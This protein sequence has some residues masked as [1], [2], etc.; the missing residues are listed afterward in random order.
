MKY[1]IKDWAG[2]VLDYTG[3]FKL[4]EF[5]VAMEFNDFYDAWNYL[6]NRFPEDMDHEG[7]FDDYSVEEKVTNNVS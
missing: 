5:A 4:P 1:I 7:F 3:V 6:Y 2:N